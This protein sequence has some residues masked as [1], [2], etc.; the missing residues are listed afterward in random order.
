M[1]YLETGWREGGKYGPN[2]HER[3]E[4]GKKLKKSRKGS[5]SS[6]PTIFV[7][8]NRRAIGI[9]EWFWRKYLERVLEKKNQSANRKGFFGQQSIG[10]CSE[11]DQG[12]FLLGNFQEEGEVRG[13]KKGNRNSQ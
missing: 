5:E 8:G 9:P 11:E 12:V 3:L 2:S 13:E 10:E 7:K 1:R 4:M 6:P